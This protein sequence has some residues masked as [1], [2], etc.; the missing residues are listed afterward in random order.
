MTELYFACEM[1]AKLDDSIDQAKWDNKES[2]VW[3][4]L[5]PHLAHKIV[6]NSNPFRLKVDC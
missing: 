4:M 6:K 3:E 5:M 1:Y 2:F